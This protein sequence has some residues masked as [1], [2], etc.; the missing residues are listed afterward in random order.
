MSRRTYQISVTT[1]TATSLVI[2]Q[3]KQATELTT[4][5]HRQMIGD[6]EYM[7]NPNP[8]KIAIGII[9]AIGIVGLIVAK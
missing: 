9:L 2:G 8:E 5:L 7:N 1:D 4:G 6:D 3:E